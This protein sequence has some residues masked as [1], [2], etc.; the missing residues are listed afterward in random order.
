MTRNIGINPNLVID[1]QKLILNLKI[2]FPEKNYTEINKK[3]DGKK[4][5]YFAKE[6]N[7]ENYEKL[8]ML[9]DKSLIPENRVTRVYPQKNLFLVTLSVK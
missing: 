4:F 5:F 8:I 3:L 6:L 2:L 7:P 9:G 1:K